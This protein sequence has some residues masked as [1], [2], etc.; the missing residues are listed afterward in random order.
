MMMPP[1]PSAVI[2]R[3]PLYFPFFLILNSTTLFSGT[4]LP[5][6]TLVEI[7]GLFIKKFLCPTLCHEN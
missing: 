2:D 3:S 4:T 7:S 5:P 1:R 6:P